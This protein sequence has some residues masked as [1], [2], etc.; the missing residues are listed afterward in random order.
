MVYIDKAPGRGRGVFAGRT[1]GPGALVEWAHVIVIPN[2]DIKGIMCHY[3]YE[4]DKR[5][6]AI[7]S[8]VSLFFNHSDTP[9]VDWWLDKK[10]RCIMFTT[11]QL[12]LS[13]DELFISYSDN[14]D[15]LKG[16]KARKARGG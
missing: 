12:V 3:C 11:N 9:N 13:G 1:I 7:A 4:W 14:P 15:F 16:E 5:N 6:C 2:R 8:G 10:R